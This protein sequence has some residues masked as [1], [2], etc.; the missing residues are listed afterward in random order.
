M[1]FTPSSSGDDGSPLLGRDAAA[2][3]GKPPLHSP[4]LHLLSHSH[5]RC[6]Q[7]SYIS[8]SSPAQRKDFHARGSVLEMR[9]VLWSFAS[10]RGNA[11]P[12]WSAKQIGTDPDTQ[13]KRLRT[14]ALQDA[15]ATRTRVSAARWRRSLVAFLRSDAAHENAKAQLQS[16]RAGEPPP[17]ISIDPMR[18]TGSHEVK[19]R[20]GEPRSPMRMGE[21]MES[22]DRP[23]CHSVH[24]R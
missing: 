24:L 2:L 10:R 18:G 23:G 22:A 14:T 7:R 21:Q 11:E 3:G 19:P 6:G 13:K 12:Q 5:D 1:P 16:T 9:R 20:N 8:F 4:H 15:T 17:S